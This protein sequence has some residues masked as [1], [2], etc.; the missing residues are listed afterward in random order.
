MTLIAS[1]WAG[2]ISRF[3]LQTIQE[4]NPL[5]TGKYRLKSRGMPHVAKG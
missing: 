3:S 2:I 5:E 1:S 4:E